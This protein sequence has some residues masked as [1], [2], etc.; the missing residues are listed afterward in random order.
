MPYQVRTELAGPRS[1]AAARA[2]TTR[3]R[4]SA[5]LI[6][7]L[8]QVWPVL[9]E[10]GA[11]TGHNVVIYHPGGN[12]ELVIDAG[13]EVQD[14]FT[15]RGPVHRVDTPAGEV[16]ATTHFGDY[17]D[18]GGA[19]AALERWCAASGRAPAGTRWEVYGDWEEDP[20]RRQTDVYF[21]L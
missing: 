10:Q 3:Q 16:A 13:V 21:L 14:G 9:R 18:L 17:A 6:A 15:A 19:Y 8:D 4:L 7:L 11:R 5:D 2:V 12:G 1:L 20:A